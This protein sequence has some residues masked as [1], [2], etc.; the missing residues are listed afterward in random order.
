[1]S[2][3]WFGG[4]IAAF[5]ISVGAD[6][7]AVLAPG[8]AITFWTAQTGGQQYT[9]LVDANGVAITS[10]T[11][12][13]GS[14]AYAPAAIP[15]FRGPVLAMWAQAGDGPYRSLMLST[16]LPAVMA[17]LTA[18][19]QQAQ[20]AAEAAAAQASEVA[21]GSSVVGHETAGDPHPT[22]L[23]APRGD[24]RYVQRRPPATGPLA[25]PLEVVEFTSTPSASDADLRQVW[26]T[27]LGVR[28][29]VS[30]LNERGFY[31]G[32]QVPGALFDA[33]LTSITAHNG[34]GR[35]LLV[36]VRGSDNVRRDAGGIDAKARLVTSEQPQVEI[37]NI[38]PGGTGRY[39]ASTAVGPAPLRVR[40]DTDDVVRMQGR[41]R[42]TSVVSG[43]H[44]MALPSGYGPLSSR[45]V[46]VPTSTG[47]VLP[48]ELLATGRVV[49]R[50]ALAGP[51]DL[52]FDDL[53]YARV[54][55]PQETGDWT[56]QSVGTATPGV[57]SPLTIAHT[58]V[59]GRLYLLVLARS[60]AGDPFTT[61]TAD[62]GGTWTRD[63]WAPTSG[64]V[65]RRI[66]MW[67]LIPSASFSTISIGFSGPGT[68]YASLYEITGHSA[69]NPIDQVASDFR[70]SSTTPAP[71]QVTPSGSGRL[72]VAAV[73]ASPNTDAQVTVSSGWTRLPTHTGGPSVA[74]LLDPPASVAAGPT[75][76]L[77]SAAGSGH[78][79]AAIR[80]A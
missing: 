56:I 34:T 27:H 30:W 11:S 6:N 78:A 3:Y 28:R 77:A 14:G 80:P 46:P 45:L 79:I 13:A 38:D 8:T 33:P 29:L 39:S 67:R 62:A 22:Y 5:V 9:D 66:E 70:A 4:D 48:V 26:V 63:T 58:G 41:V 49:A 76:T 12:S 31:R 50:A 35:A 55:A 19:A 17:S 75:W 73:A 43:D 53:T 60:S 2:Q 18:A 74:Y 72:L 7:H 54:L 20:T 51:V 65:G 16:D 61:V 10:V 68:A 32:E 40:W 15:R 47:Q 52:S 71:V 24:G 64:S 42:A 25:E 21:S 37:A 1:M 23:T 69:A 57:T 44:I 59:V 36:Q